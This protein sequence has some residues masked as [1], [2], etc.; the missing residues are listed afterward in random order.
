MDKAID[1]S[2]L[3]R[4]RHLYQSAPIQTMITGTELRWSGNT[5]LITYPVSPVHFHGGSGLHGAVYFKLLDD[6][7]YFAAAAQEADYFLLTAKFEI[8]LR[9]QVTGGILQAEGRLL[10]RDQ[11]IFLAE[12]SLRD[13][14]GTVVAFGSGRFSRSEKRWD[15]LPGYCSFEL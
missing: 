5:V 15:T 9:K 1:R 11:H 14:S 2:H 13:A 4:L 12:S 6:A 8:N 10:Q 7:A 3:E